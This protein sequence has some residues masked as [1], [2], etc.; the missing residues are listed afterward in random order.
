VKEFEMIDTRNNRTASEHF[1]PAR[2]RCMQKIAV[3]LGMLSLICATSLAD[4]A[5]WFYWKNIA[6]GDRICAQFPPEDGW[7]KDGG[8]FK[9]ARCANRFR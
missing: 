6:T 2:V 9:D 3:A 4:P 5:P 7:M 1:M 8:P